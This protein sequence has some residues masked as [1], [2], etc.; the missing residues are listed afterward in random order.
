MTHIP[1]SIA[2]RIEAFERFCYSESHI[3]LG[4][5]SENCQMAVTREDLFLLA[6]VVVKSFGPS[7][8]SE[9]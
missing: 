7:R 1:D 3:R 2:V 8:F 9:Q 4:Y 6:Y 5:R